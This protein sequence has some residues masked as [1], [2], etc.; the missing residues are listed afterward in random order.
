MKAISG[1][2]KIYGVFGYPIHHTLSPAMHNAAFKHLGID[3]VYVAF[4]VQPEGISDALKGISALGIKGINLT[5]PH[6]QICVPYIK[7]LSYE[8]RITLSVNTVVVKEDGLYGYSTD[9]QGFIKA[10][11][12]SLQWQPKQKSVLILGCGGASRAVGFQSAIEGATKIYL[13]DI[14]YNRS[15]EL[16]RDIKRNIKSCSVFAIKQERLKD[17]IKQ[18]DCL[19]QAT[20]LGMEKKDPLPM[21][22]GLLHRGLVVYDLVY[23]VPVTPLV[24]EARKRKIKAANGLM[25]LLYQGALSFELWTGKK[26][27][28]EVMKKALVRAI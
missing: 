2:T 17:C 26:A 18:C 19:V 1:R 4:E 23:N 8:A 9:G 13:T 24:K 25:M 10:V 28:I 27:P 21:D 7:Q 11:K 14:I 16:A 22:I 15:L 3:A 5:I 6:K 12:H 20:P